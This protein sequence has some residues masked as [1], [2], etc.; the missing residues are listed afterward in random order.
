MPVQHGRRHR[1]L[2]AELSLKAGLRAMVDQR[3]QGLARR[4]HEDCLDLPRF[5]RLVP[6]SLPDGVDG[7][8][9]RIAARVQLDGQPA[10]DGWTLEDRLRIGRPHEPQPLIECRDVG[11]C[12]RGCHGGSPQ[13]PFDREAHLQRLGLGPECAMAAPG[14]RERQGDRGGDLLRIELHRHAGRHGGRRSTGRARRVPAGVVMGPAELRAQAGHDPGTG[15]YAR[16][17]PPAASV[18]DTQTVLMW[19][20]EGR[21]R[22]S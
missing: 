5:H 14:R 1:V 22:S 21:C 8:L 15:E 17:S 13:T 7:A 20:V 4:G 16:A 9:Q 12:S 18:A 10:G 11:R 2:E 6:E 19:L 3:A